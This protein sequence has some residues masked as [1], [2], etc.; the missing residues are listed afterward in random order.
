VSVITEDEKVRCRHHLGYNN[1]SRAATF[2]LGVPT[3]LE[4][5]FMIEGAFNFILPTAE[6]RLRKML[7]RMDQIE[8]QIED[9][10]ENLEVSKIGEIEVRPDTFEQLRKRYLWWQGAIANMLGVQP[11][12]F[13]FRPWLGMGYNGG[14]G[15]NVPIRN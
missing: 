10:M 7:D 12:P 5:A 8:C 4:T 9:N 11:N 1:F 2:V 6:A 14:G 13:D 15:M 3:G